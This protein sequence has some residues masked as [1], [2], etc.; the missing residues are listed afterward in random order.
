M[1]AKFSSN[2]STYVLLRKYTR[3][4]IN[5]FRILTYVHKLSKWVSGSLNGSSGYLYNYLMWSFD[6]IDLNLKGIPQTTAE[7]VWKQVAWLCKTEGAYIIDERVKDVQGSVEW[8]EIPNVR[9]GASTVAGVRRKSKTSSCTL[10]ICC[11]VAHMKK[12][13]S[14]DHS[15]RTMG[16]TCHFFNWFT[17]VHMGGFWSQSYCTGTTVWIIDFKCRA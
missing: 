7:N 1:P 10:S 11:P 6:A 16:K 2:I 3:G 17:L 8:I 14:R 13:G 4:P 12:N 15:H 9:W 5:L